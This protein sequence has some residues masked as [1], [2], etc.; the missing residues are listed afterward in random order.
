MAKQSAKPFEIVEALGIVGEGLFQGQKSS[1]PWKDLA[2]QWSLT[3]AP[4]SEAPVQIKSRN[5]LR[6]KTTTKKIKKKTLKANPAMSRLTR[7]ASTK[8]NISD[9][10]SYSE[11]EDHFVDLSDHVSQGYNVLESIMPTS[12]QYVS[13]SQEEYL[14]HEEQ[15]SSNM[16][17]PSEYFNAMELS[18]R[19]QPFVNHRDNNRSSISHLGYSASK[20]KTSNFIMPTQPLRPSLEENLRPA[21]FSTIDHYSRLT[22]SPVYHGKNIKAI[23]PSRDDHMGNNTKQSRGSSLHNNNYDIEF[24]SDNDAFTNGGWD[25]DNDGDKR[26]VKKPF[27]L[28]SRFQ[29]SD[30]YRNEK[31]DAYNS[32][33]MKYLKTEFKGKQKPPK[34]PSSPNE[35]FDGYQ[36]IK[37][38]ANKET[39][40]IHDSNEEA[41]QFVSKDST[42]DKNQAMYRRISASGHVS[43]FLQQDTLDLPP[44]E[45]P[46]ADYTK[47]GLNR[48]GAKLSI[49]GDL[50]NESFK[51]ND[52][53][54]SM[55]KQNE[56]GNNKP[57]QTISPQTLESLE[58]LRVEPNIELKKRSSSGYNILKEVVHDIVKT[59][60]HESSFGDYSKH[61]IT[62]QQPLK[63]TISNSI[64]QFASSPRDVKSENLVNPKIVQVSS[65][66]ITSN[67][68][69]TGRSPWASE[70]G[71]PSHSITPSTGIALLP[72]LNHTIPS[73]VGQ[74]NVVDSSIIPNTIQR[75]STTSRVSL[76]SNIDVPS[77]TQILEVVPRKS[78]KSEENI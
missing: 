58:L 71:D 35:D 61:G 64:D 17:Y 11:D 36:D 29:N 44:H 31:L 38:I 57:L 13:N 8:I 55:N 77:Y 2:K 69:V 74:S 48:E 72:S 40:G 21:R 52:D 18:N 43:L 78:S 67:F 73:V 68:V 70:T 9:L 66:P 62:K 75:S 63:D 15:S 53:S 45:S 50:T 32:S 76:Y 12:L 23:R 39:E 56:L 46:F 27:Y 60:P 47:H 10:D 30:H 19:D 14:S 26:N 41:N 33:N 59:L 6:P 22:G 4:Q 25:E 20:P 42:L 16:S 49:N 51:N 54:R 28:E 37:P 7:L 3:L 1:S 5:D 24:D 65:V 34:F